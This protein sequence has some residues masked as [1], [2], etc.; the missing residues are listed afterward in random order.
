MKL[1]AGAGGDRG[2][3]SMDFGH[4]EQIRHMVSWL[5]C[6]WIRFLR[7]E[8]D[9]HDEIIDCEK[10]LSHSLSSRKRSHSRVRRQT[11]PPR[12]HTAGLQTIVRLGNNLGLRQRSGFYHS[13]EKPPRIRLDIRPRSRPKPGQVKQGK[14]SDQILILDRLSHRK[15]GGTCSLYSTVVSDISSY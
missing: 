7:L 3:R 13:L 15:Y 11:K 1:R 9:N 2:G 14:S 10:N 8:R 12:P 4:K 5:T 6:H